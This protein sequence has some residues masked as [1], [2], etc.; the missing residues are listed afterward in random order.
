MSKPP[1][2]VTLTWDHALEF[3]GQ[4]GNHEVGLDGSSY[5]APSPMAMLALSL[6]GCMAIDLVHIL[7]RGRHPVTALTTTFTGERATEEPHRFVKIDLAFTIATSAS[8]EQ[9][10]R[11]LALSRNKYCSVWNSLRQ[12][13][14]FNVT[15]ELKDEA[16]QTQ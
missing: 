16:A 15:Y 10:D 2:N 4:S 14:E 1:L 3:T 6:A 9:V 13:I 11:A 12:D 5:T 7:T 8:V